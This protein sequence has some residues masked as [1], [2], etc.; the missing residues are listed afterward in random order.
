MQNVE[1]E[2]LVVVVFLTLGK[3]RSHRY[4]KSW[5]MH[6]KTHLHLLQ[7]SKNENMPQD[8]I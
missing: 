8:K 6:R 4:L 3:S 1:I 5:H 7:L 2:L